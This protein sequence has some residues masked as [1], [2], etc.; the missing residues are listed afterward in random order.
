M[1]KSEVVQVSGRGT[2]VEFL[3]ND[4][5]PFDSITDALREY[6]EEHRNLWSG[7]DITVNAGS[8]T[9]SHDQLSE[10]KE[11]IERGSGL[12]VAKFS[13]GTEG[14]DSGNITPIEFNTPAPAAEPGPAAAPGQVTPTGSR[15]RP[16]TR[17]G[18][19][20][21]PDD[22]PST[23]WD[24]ALLVKATC[25]SGEFIR[26]DGDVVVLGDVNPGAEVIA[27][28]DIAVFG[29]LRGFAHAGSKGNTRST[30]LALNLDSPRIQIGPHA[31][32]SAQAG[33]RPKGPGTGPMIAY[34]RRRSIHLAPFVGGLANYGK[35]EPYD[36]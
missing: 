20:G 16:G 24:T 25:R 33:Q 28:G 34:V 2:D 30:I 8:R 14:I 6:L 5:V 31:G 26:H 7:G 27:E 18:Q 11:I 23:R 1:L 36:G 22:T 19:G 10:L 29:Q 13:C 32:T 17:S 12:K 4:V 35:G 9:V 15:S 21:R 3:I